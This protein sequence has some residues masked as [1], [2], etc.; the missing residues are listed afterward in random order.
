[1]TL[2]ILLVRPLLMLH[3]L[4]LTFVLFMLLCVEVTTFSIQYT[5]AVLRVLLLVLK[6]QF[7]AVYTIMYWQ[8]FL[9]VVNIVGVKKS[10]F[11]VEVSKLD[12]KWSWAYNISVLLKPKSSIC[13]IN[14]VSSALNF[15]GLNT[16]NAK[17]LFTQQQQFESNTFTTKVYIQ[18]HIAL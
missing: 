2:R 8:Y 14:F 9:Q 6:L 7:G 17:K 5:T 18:Y 4:L 11:G 3:T 1:M 16:V 15:I 13:N 12:E 10:N